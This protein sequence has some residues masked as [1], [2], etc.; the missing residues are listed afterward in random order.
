VPL[1]LPT[2]PNGCRRT[3]LRAAGA[4]FLL[5]ALAGAAHAFEV[6]LQGVYEESGVLRAEIRLR[7]VFDERIEASL[8]R[9]MPATLL[10]HAELWRSRTAWFDRLVSNADVSIKVR[11]EA[12]RSRYRIERPGL[13]TLDFDSIDSVRTMLS[14][15]I[16]MPV[17]RMN[18]VKPM[19]RH[20][21]MISVTLQP[22]TVEDLREG[23]EWLSGEVEAGRDAGF[24]VLTSLPRSVFDAL[25]DYAGLGDR[26]ARSVSNEFYPES[27]PVDWTKAPR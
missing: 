25:R 4:G 11:Y 20:Y 5:L 15:A 6:S 3:L 17:G 27:L 26:R 1:S 8:S 2:G 21:V 18:A 12:L 23:E 22:M 19:S 24:G 14:R 16:P 13:P 10:I 7:D 9:G